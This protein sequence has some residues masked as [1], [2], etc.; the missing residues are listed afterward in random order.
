M[1]EGYSTEGMTLLTEEDLRLF[2]EGTNSRLYEKLGAHL[3]DG[4]SM[5]CHFAVWAPSARSVSVVGESNSWDPS[6]DPLQLR[7]HSGV[8][9]GLLDGVE[10]GSPYMYHVVPRRRRKGTRKADP[11]A[12]HCQV[13]PE[14]SSIAWDIS[15]GWGDEEWM[16]RR[17]KR[18]G[19]AAPIT[20][21]EVHV[22]SWRRAR[23][24]GGHI[25]YRALAS[26]LA[27]YVTDMGYTH[28]EFLPLMEH[29]FY[30]SWGYQTTGYFAPSSRYG[31][32]QDLMYLIDYL[33]QRD[34]GVV[35]DWV[36]SHTATDEWALGLFDGTHLY[37]YEDPRKGRHPDWGSLVFDYSRPQVRSFLMS[38][39]MF[40]L[41]VYH[42]D[43]LRVDGVAS[44]LYLDYSRKKGEWVPNEHG[45]REN[46][47]AISFL[48][49][50]N[51]A[52]YRDH[53]DVQTF[54]EESTA[55]P[56][57]TRPTYLGGL[58]FG[59]KWDLGWMHDTLKYMSRDPAHRRY[60]HDRVTFRM[61]YAFSE[62]FILPL[63]HDEVVHLKG[64]LLEKM[65]G[66]D[67]EKFA[68]LR[69]LLGYMFA[70]PGKKLLFMGDEFGQRREWDHEAAL[71]WDLLD[72]PPHQRLQRWVKDLNHL[73]TSEPDLHALDC[74]PATFEWVDWSDAE[75]SVLSF[76][77]RGPSPRGAMLIICN[78]TPV[79][80]FGFRVGVPEGKRW[81]VVLNSDDVIYGGSGRLGEA[82][83][84]AETVAHD[85]RPNSI[86]L[87]LPPL[88]VLFL[89]GEERAAR[90]RKVEA[91]R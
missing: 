51:E 62:N 80:R 12:F 42:A 31:T 55:W 24:G 3:S 37:E 39:A 82:R 7:D 86:R 75:R 9:E 35:L 56:M 4:A 2:T 36:P 25:S 18:N 63:S 5:G 77:R 40:W 19:L 57:V 21:Y 15:Y 60:H 91:K 14:T 83:I 78:F 67:R 49:E 48:R 43:G 32:P 13:P 33:H 47:E 8:W 11:M 66:N 23:K 1:Q 16:S 84:R 30:G 89:H 85:R 70:L 41:D 65:P 52:V 38:S 59:L 64:S 10:A 22:G 26:P 28:V 58:G 61:V 20:I 76:L 54:A 6:S 71:D 45:G 74:D 29:P 73:Y 88:S 68:N 53:P 87:V 34:I 17:A 44:M 90:T 79:T 81:R 69:L 46:L 50:L 72:S 27:D